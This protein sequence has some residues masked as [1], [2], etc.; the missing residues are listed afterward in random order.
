[1]TATDS[2]PTG[3]QHVLPGADKAS[4]AMMGCHCEAFTVA[5][6]ATAV[7]Y[8]LVFGRCRASGP[9]P[10]DRTGLKQAGRSATPL[11]QHRELHF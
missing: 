2:T 8:R 4:D 7:R 1:M 10:N 6:T 3:P 11:P 5:R 9:I